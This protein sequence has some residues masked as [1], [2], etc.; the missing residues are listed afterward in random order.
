MFVLSTNETRDHED[1]NTADFDWDS[2]LL[3]EFRQSRVGKSSWSSIPDMVLLITEIAFIFLPLTIFLNI[4]CRVLIL[5]KV[6]IMLKCNAPGWLLKKS[7]Q[8]ICPNC[9]HS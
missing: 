6:I 9:D 5:N 1:D 3:A 4:R 2:D 7:D 8:K